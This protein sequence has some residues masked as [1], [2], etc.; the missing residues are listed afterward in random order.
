MPKKEKYIA[1]IPARGGSKE[2]KNKNILEIGSV[3]LIAYSIKA[4]KISKRISDVYVSTDSTKIAKIARDYG[5]YVIK[6]P[7]HLAT[8][9]AKQDDVIPPA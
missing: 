1:I 2:L 8:D 4:A 9:S 3:P 6:R 5:A 7:G